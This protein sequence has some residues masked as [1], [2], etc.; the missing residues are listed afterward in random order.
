MNLYADYSIELVLLLL[1]VAAGPVI[2]YLA[3]RNPRQ[4][5]K[6]TSH[7]FITSFALFVS[8]IDNIVS[9]ALL[10]WLRLSLFMRP[11]LWTMATSRTRQSLRDLVVAV[12]KSIFFYI[13]IAVFLLIMTVNAVVLFGRD[14]TITPNEFSD[15][16]VALRVLQEAIT[17]VNYPDVMIP[18]YASSRWSFVYW[19]MFFCIGFFFI[20][21]MLLGEIRANYNESRSRREKKFFQVRAHQLQLAFNHLVL[22]PKTELKLPD[23]LKLIMK[24]KELYPFK[25]GEKEKSMAELRVVQVLGTEFECD[26]HKFQT[27]ILPIIQA[28][29]SGLDGSFVFGVL[30]VFINLSVV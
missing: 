19:F 18:Q 9:F 28:K 29:F 16:A 10:K 15:F 30:C 6:P 1:L 13:A 3:C 17:T 7:T 8:I 5:F 20:L 12:W 27:S 14:P 23:L 25:G 21:P 4:F 26:R 11:V 22:S 24:F 2:Q